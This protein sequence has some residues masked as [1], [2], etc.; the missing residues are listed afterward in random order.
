[1]WGFGYHRLKSKNKKDN[2][3]YQITDLLQLSRKETE[4]R[5]GVLQAKHRF[6]AWKKTHASHEDGRRFAYVSLEGFIL[7]RQMRDTILFYK[8]VKRDRVQSFNAYIDRLPV[9]NNVYGAAQ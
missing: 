7:K 5:L 3:D 4:A 1:M 9:A 2:H 6:E 8:M